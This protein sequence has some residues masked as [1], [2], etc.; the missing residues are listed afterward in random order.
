ML[1]FA[2]LE[3]QAP[4]KKESVLDIFRIAYLR[5]RTFILGLIWC[6]LH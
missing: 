6:V 1:S 5:K 3:T 2:K 4:L